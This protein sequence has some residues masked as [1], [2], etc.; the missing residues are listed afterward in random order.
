MEALHGTVFWIFRIGR[1]LSSD[2]ELREVRNYVKESFTSGHNAALSFPDNVPLTSRIMGL[3]LV[4]KDMAQ[5]YG[6]EFALVKHGTTGRAEYL[7]VLKCLH[8]RIVPD[9]QELLGVTV[10][11]ESTGI[12]Q[13]ETG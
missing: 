13:L 1:V 12:P 11:P 3:V 6:R 7:T 5:N 2:S 8:I 9:E 4:C 10:H